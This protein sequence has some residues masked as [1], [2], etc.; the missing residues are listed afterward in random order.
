MSYSSVLIVILRDIAFYSHLPCELYRMTIGNNPIAPIQND[1][2]IAGKG[3]VPP[4]H[5]QRNEAASNNAERSGGGD[6]PGRN[7]RRTCLNDRRNNNR[8]T[9][10]PAAPSD[11]NIPLS[12]GSQQSQ[13]RE[14]DW[15]NCAA[16]KK[17]KEKQSDNWFQDWKRTGCSPKNT[18]MSCLCES[19]K[20]KYYC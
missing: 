3:A 15:A 5:N 18:E 1:N 12:S 20:P 6:P 10:Q 14:N 19:P 16:Q 13:E 7:P 9:P 8:P 2:P 4:M 11:T 17:T